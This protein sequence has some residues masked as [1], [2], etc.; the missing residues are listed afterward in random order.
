MSQAAYNVFGTILSI[1]LY[2]FSIFPKKKHWEE[3]LKS[4]FYVLSKKFSKTIHKSHEH[5][6]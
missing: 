3:N 6:F 5:N 4:E 2:S 1:A